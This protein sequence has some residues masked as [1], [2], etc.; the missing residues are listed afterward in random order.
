MPFDGRYL[1][2]QFFRSIPSIRFVNRVRPREVDQADCRAIADQNVCS[3]ESS[4]Y[5]A[6]SV[7]PVILVPC[8][9]SAVQHSPG[10]E[11]R[12]HSRHLCAKVDEAVPSSWI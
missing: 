2:P 4:V 12:S 9:V 1:L 7:K 6:K 5:D 10:D 3:I 8:A 11:N